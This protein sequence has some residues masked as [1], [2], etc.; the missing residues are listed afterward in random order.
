MSEVKKSDI[1]NYTSLRWM[2]D[3]LNLLLEGKELQWRRKQVPGH[4]GEMPSAKWEYFSPYDIGNKFYHYS[5]NSIE[6]RVKPEVMIMPLSMKDIGKRM[7]DGL[8]LNVRLKNGM[9]LLEFQSCSKY[10]VQFLTTLFEDTRN[11]TYAELAE[12]C[13]FDD[14]MDCFHAMPY[15]QESEKANE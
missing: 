13:E 12:K 9:F 5:E 6:I 11:Y 15:K 10:G 3:I 4:W 7:A 14:G 2:A 8:T 1:A